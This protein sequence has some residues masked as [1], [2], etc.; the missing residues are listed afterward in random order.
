MS[1]YRELNIRDIGGVNVPIG[2]F[3][4]SGKLSILT[5]DECTG[6]CNIYNIKCVIDIRTPVE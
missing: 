3:I 5:P 2:L 4:R 6:L 1:K